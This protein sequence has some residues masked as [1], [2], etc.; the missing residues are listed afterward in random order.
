MTVLADA[1][2]FD[3]FV[4]RN[5]ADDQ[6]EGAGASGPIIGKAVEDMGK[7][8]A[9]YAAGRVNPV[10]KAAEANWQTAGQCLTVDLMGPS[11]LAAGEV[12]TITAKVTNVF[13]SPETDLL[14]SDGVGIRPI[15]W[16]GSL[17]P[18]DGQVTTIATYPLQPGDPWFR[19][20]APS[21]P[22]PKTAHPGF[23]IHVTST[24][25]V[26]DAK[27]SFSNLQRVK[28]Q[29]SVSWTQT[30]PASPVSGESVQGGD[31]ASGTFKIKMLSQTSP[32]LGQEWTSIGSSYDVNDKLDSSW[33]DSSTGCSGS[34][35]G[36]MSDSGALKDPPQQVPRH[37]IVANWG[38]PYSAWVGFSITVD[39]TETVKETTSGPASCSPG[40]FTYKN[41]ETFDPTCFDQ[42]G[43]GAPGNVYGR[44]KGNAAG[45][46]GKIAISCSGVTGGIRFSAHGSLTVS[47]SASG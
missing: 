24:A 4:A 40:T 11:V 6:D 13:N 41:P 12:A 3:Q 9:E 38:P 10:I 23:N 43:P 26:A 16:T 25:G 21:T 36:S 8:F 37:I 20:T 34:S 15:D 31:T 28:I 33:K 39:G 7:A 45:D 42:M 29:G 22:W 1:N 32:P 5:A 2:T 35:I 17:D 14:G 47:P 44:F 46:S 30:V 18:P 27:I 19:Y